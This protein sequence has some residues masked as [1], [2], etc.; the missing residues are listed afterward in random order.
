MVELCTQFVDAPGKLSLR[1]YWNS[2][3][4]QMTNFARIFSGNVWVAPEAWGQADLETYTI[5][6]AA[7]PTAAEADGSDRSD[8]SL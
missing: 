4:A 3:A 8:L 7:L 5:L 2:P 6:R 1:G